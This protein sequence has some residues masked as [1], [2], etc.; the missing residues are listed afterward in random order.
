MVFLASI[1]IAA[2]AFAAWSRNRRNTQVAQPALIVAIV[3]II[4]A[5]GQSLTV[6][7]AGNVG[8]QDFFG[9]VSG[10]TLHA[11]INIRNPLARIIKFSIKTQELKEMMDVPSQEGLNVG[12]EV[13]ILFHLNPEKAAD[14]YK[15]VGPGRPFY[16][17]RPLSL[18]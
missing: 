7:P 13:S 2:A 9:M 6:I 4:S 8:V 1:V 5:L 17:R 10:R 12:V 15:T 16:I 14:V 3:A 11:G 18:D